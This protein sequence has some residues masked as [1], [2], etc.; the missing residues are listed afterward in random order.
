MAWN[1]VFEEPTSVAPE[2]KYPATVHGIHEM[3]GSYGP[4]VRIDFKVTSDDEA[5][6]GQ[7]SGLAN[8]RFSEN[9]KLGRWITAI[10]GRTPNI[11]EEIT[12]AQLTG[13][14]CCVV[15]RH[16][17]SA[18]GKVF[19]NVTDVLGLAKEDDGVPF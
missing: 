9:T 4:V 14:E 3:D 18:D 5:E 17:T 10:L 19:A 6:G 8:K 1:G 7:V 12:A 13:K 15:V 11:G 2:G 16:K